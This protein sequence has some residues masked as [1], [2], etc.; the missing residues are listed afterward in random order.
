MVTLLLLLHYLAKQEAKK[1]H[2][3]LKQCLLLA[4]T[5]KLPAGQVKPPFV[6]K[7]CAPN[8]TRRK[9]A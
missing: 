4:D 3:S 2:F 1:L 6:H 7:A 5:L 9:G 8:R